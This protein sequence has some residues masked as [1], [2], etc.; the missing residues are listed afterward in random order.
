MNTP[1][2]IPAARGRGLLCLLALIAM[3]WGAGL[4]GARADGV[5]TDCDQES[6]QFA[7]DGGGTIT[8]DCDG[9][10]TLTNTIVIQQDTTLD[11]TGRNVTFASLGAT[12]GGVRLFS[13][14]AG[15]T[16]TLIN[17]ALVDGFS[18]NGAAVLVEAEGIL[19]AISC[20]FSNNVAAGSNGL[21]GAVGG[22]DPNAVNGRAGRGGQAGRI[23]A[24]G[25]I[26]NL[27]SAA[28]VSC[29]FLTNSALGG[30]GGNGGDGAAGS[31]TGGNGGA[32]GR[33]GSALGGAIYN[34]GDLVVSNSSFRANYSVAGL[35]GDGGAAGTGVFNGLS[36]RGSA[37]GAA[38][39][40]AVF[41]SRF[42]SAILD[43]STFSLNGT[44]SGDS[45]SAENGTGTARRGP[46]GV[47]SSGGGVA[48]Y[49]TNILINSTFFANAAVAGGGGS[50]GASGFRGGAGGNGGNAWGGN[51]F[52]GGRTARTFSTNCTF[53]DG[54]AVPGTNG[55]G[56]SGDFPGANGKR[57]LSRGANVANSNGVFVLRNTLIAYANRGTNGYGTFRDDGFNLSS[58]RS[59]KFSRT[60]G[61]RT[62]IDPKLDLLR[63]NGGQVETMELLSGSP[64]ID[65]GTNLGAPLV[66]SRGVAR[67][68][69]GRTDIGSY[70]TGQR[71]LPPV[72]SFSPSDRK[73]RLGSATTFRVVATGDD[74]IT[75]RWRFRPVTG[76]GLLPPTFADLPGE[77]S[78]SYAI[79]GVLDEN[80]G[81]YQVLVSNNSG[82]STSGLGT[83]T[84]VEAPTIDEDPA[85]PV[86]LGAGNG[87]SLVVTASGDA[88]L[89]YRWLS[90]TVVIPGAVLSNYSVAFALP[91]DSA[92]YTVEVCNEVGCVLSLGASVTVTQAPP[93]VVIAPASQVVARGAR[94]TFTASASGG[95]PMTFLW[96]KAGVTVFIENNFTTGNSSFVLSSAQVA[97]AVSYRVI[98]T[99]DLGSVTSSVAT[100][101][102]QTAAPTITS[103]PV[104]GLAIEFT[105]F[106]LSVTATGSTPLSYQWFRL[107]G[108]TGVA[109]SGA[110]NSSLVFTNIRR[111]DAA[112]YYVNVGNHLATRKSANAVVNVQ[113][114]RPDFAVQPADTNLFLGDTLNL[115]PSVLGSLLTYQWYFNSTAISGA[116]NG[117]LVVTNAQLTNTGAYSLSVTNAAGGTNS[118]VANVTVANAAPVISL[119]PDPV[120][121]VQGATNRVVFTVS[122]IGSKPFYFQWF[123]N[124]APLSEASRVSLNLTNSASGT[125]L[126][127]S[128]TLSSSSLILIGVTP[129]DEGVYRSN[130]TNALGTA[131]SDDTL[132]DVLGGG[133]GF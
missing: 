13:V 14:E 33:G 3:A 113:L 126:L 54:S 133:V 21:S 24:G 103:Q 2:A 119:Q 57:G 92:E 51:V 50:G 80:E 87:F 61:S 98:I 118:T 99:N 70:E 68:N 25:A 69:G 8:F 31:F 76:S 9:T 29:A 101:T 85:G 12:N 79:A 132:L 115:S 52:N 131:I 22:A 56:G 91:K 16:L 84:V 83:L 45:A 49:G 6:L 105:N 77:T 44:A 109:V 117:S 46:G 94:V 86:E 11:G 73:V 15:V 88:P 123:F 110:T 128:N 53:S 40:A 48:N 19:Q 75:Y 1:F 97:D 10:I 67:P 5:V 64:A 30:A 62:N 27:G 89:R 43:S 81:D 122:A 4:G 17:V 58:D 130:V 112:T 104:G 78:D 102:V 42:G 72:I 35:A 63:D 38:S 127:M 34:A 71:L 93:M 37:G 114:V 65:G 108:A 23:G 66:D 116:T 107:S 7:V 47:D 55:F 41:T 36:G 96:Q 111:A 59:I 32:G 74:P 90:N 124:D 28:V 39:G 95:P 120:S 18:T 60:S 125:R 106:S 26:Y 20:V 82:T 129:Q 121:S 100:L